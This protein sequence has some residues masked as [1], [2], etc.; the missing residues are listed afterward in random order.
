[1][2]SID[3]DAER[4]ADLGDRPHGSPSS[5]LREKG[6]GKWRGPASFVGDGEEGEEEE[7]ESGWARLDF[8]WW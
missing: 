5:S 3:G 7:G 4:Q 2:G 6:K 8:R 1:M